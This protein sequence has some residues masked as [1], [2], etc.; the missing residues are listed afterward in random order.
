LF[1]DASADM[2]P[3]TYDNTSVSKHLNDSFPEIS[4]VFGPNLT[5]MAKANWSPK[6]AEGPIKITKKDGI[7]FADSYLNVDLIASNSTVVNKT[8]ATFEL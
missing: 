7:R 3:Y 2:F 8:V 1:K 4:K 5:L 6:N